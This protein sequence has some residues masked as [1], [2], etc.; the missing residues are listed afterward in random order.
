[1]QIL[2]QRRHA[3]VHLSILRGEWR[4]G[5]VSHLSSPYF[6]T[7]FTCFTGAKSTNTDAVKYSGANGGRAACLT[8]H[9][10]LPSA[11]WYAV[12]LLYWYKS[13]NTDVPRL[14]SPLLGRQSRLRRLRRRLCRYGV[15]LLYWYK[16]TN[17]EA[18]PIEAVVCTRGAEA[19][20]VSE[21]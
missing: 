13:T 14:P 12:Y 3:S 10:L 16:S 11:G 9:L 1:M 7:Q 21:K 20:Q 19:A 17:T 18:A 4:A 2:T 8:S 6:T 15:Y 5:C